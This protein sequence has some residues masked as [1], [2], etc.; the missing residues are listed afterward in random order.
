MGTQ[1]GRFVVSSITGNSTTFPQGTP[2]DR[3]SIVRYRTSRYEPR[4][5]FPTYVGYILPD[6]A[7]PS[8]HV[9]VVESSNGQSKVIC[10]P[11]PRGLMPTPDQFLDSQ[12][13][14]TRFCSLRTS[15]RINLRP[16]LIFKNVSRIFDRLKLLVLRL[17][18]SSVVAIEISG[19]DSSFEP[20]YG[21]GG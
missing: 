11:L 16:Q 21:P 10:Y 7:F 15:Q 12:A 13:D 5:G 6:L 18:I 9:G 17:G 19:S 14:R 20:P 3:G 4:N 8:L 2:L 1:T